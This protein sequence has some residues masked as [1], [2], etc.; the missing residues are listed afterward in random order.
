MQLLYGW[1]H[2]ERR[3]LFWPGKYEAENEVPP[4]LFQ[5]NLSIRKDETTNPPTKLS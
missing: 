5:M 4:P 1:W 2:F 3:P